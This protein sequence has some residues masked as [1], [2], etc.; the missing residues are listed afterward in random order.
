MSACVRAFVHACVRARVCVRA[1]VC[2]CVRACV[3]VYRLPPP[4]AVVEL[5]SSSEVKGCIEHRVVHRVSHNPMRFWVEALRMTSLR[6][7]S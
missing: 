5:L 1:C 4:P 2:A 3:C 7:T 6:M